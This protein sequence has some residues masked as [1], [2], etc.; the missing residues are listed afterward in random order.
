[1]TVSTLTGRK[2]GPWMR[3]TIWALMALAGIGLAIPGTVGTAAAGTAVVVAIATPL[4]RVVWIVI[5]LAQERDHRF[6]Y[7]GLALLGAVGLGV[8]ASTFL[9]F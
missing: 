4:L 3:I 9:T 1:M 8:L 5:R 2:Q 7:V 6:V